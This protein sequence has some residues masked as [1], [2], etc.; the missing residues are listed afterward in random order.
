MIAA[1]SLA[2]QPLTGSLT[3]QDEN[4]SVP[5]HLANDEQLNDPY[6]CVDNVFG[7]AT[8]LWPLLHRLAQ[9]TRLESPIETTTSTHSSSSITGSSPRQLLLAETH[10]RISLAALELSIKEWR[11][12]LELHAVNM[13]HAASDSSLQSLLQNAEAYRHAALVHLYCHCGDRRESSRIQNAVQA[14]LQC[15][16]RVIVFGKPFGGLLWPLFTAGASAITSNQRN[17]ASTVCGQLLELQGLANIANAKSLLNEVWRQMD[18]SDEI[19][20]WQDV[21]KKI[22]W[23]IVLA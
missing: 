12:Q 9:L 22:G 19:L 4:P 7:L 16:L 21:A 15:C 13:E 10:N 8:S 23:S 1:L 17:I 14:A 5:T 20:R 6:G 18:D 2:K 3:Y 11:P